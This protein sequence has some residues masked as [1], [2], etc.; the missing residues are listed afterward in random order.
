M[1]ENAKKEK[2]APSF[3]LKYK[4]SIVSLTS[5]TDDIFNLQFQIRKTTLN[6]DPNYAQSNTQNICG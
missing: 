2:Q 6:N 5:I 3:V 1:N 4:R